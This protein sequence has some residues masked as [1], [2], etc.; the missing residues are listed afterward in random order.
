VSN[1][2]ELTGSYQVVLM[3]DGEIFDVRDMTLD[4][5]A[6]QTIYFDITSVNVGQHDID[7]NGLSGSFEVQSVPTPT[8]TVTTEPVD[9][10]IDSFGV[11]PRYD[12]NNNVLV[13]TAV[14]YEVNET[15]LSSPDNK[16]LL[17]VFHDGE[18]LDT[19]SLLDIEGI[20]TGSNIGSLTYIPSRGWM[21]GE[22]TFQAELYQGEK[23]LQV[24]PMQTLQF[25][26]PEIKTVSWKTLGIIIGAA[27]IVAIVVVGLVLYYRRDMF[28]GY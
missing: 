10:Q 5:G 18:L 27:L 3:V 1:A 8:I 13:S 23:L 15:C 12:G 24:T 17:K 7:V 26:V 25:T 16:L 19:V 22:Y 11:S 6:G 20:D 21:N 2:G 9:P 4:G 14:S 28:K